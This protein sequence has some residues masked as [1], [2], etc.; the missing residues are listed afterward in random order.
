MSKQ[1]RRSESSDKTSARY[2]QSRRSLHA[3]NCLK[4]SLQ[5]VHGS[6]RLTVGEK[7]RGRQEERKKKEERGREREKG[8]VYSLH[9]LLAPSDLL[10]LN[11]VTQIEGRASQL[12]YF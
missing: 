5:K 4:K 7:E 1:D 11:A 8:S 10:K 2:R 9:T 12:P 3:Q 6:K